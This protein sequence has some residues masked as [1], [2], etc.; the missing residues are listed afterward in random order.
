MCRVILQSGELAV[1]KL[2]LPRKFF[3]GLTSNDKTNLK[4]LN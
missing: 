3:N 1:Y 4:L 2:I